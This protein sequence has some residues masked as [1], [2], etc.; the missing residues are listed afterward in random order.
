MAKTVVGLF[1][2]F[3]EAQSVVQDLVSNGFSRDHISVV[4]N[5]RSQTVDTSR[6]VGE[7]NTAAEGAGAGAV[8]G[9]VVGG[10]V[11][12]LVGLGVLAIPGIGPVLAAGP[13]VA[14][15]G[16]PAAVAGATALGAGLG[17]A[18]GGLVGGLIGAGVPED[19]A[20]YY[21]E[22]VRRGGTLVSVTTDD[23]SMADRAYN[24]MRQHNAVDIKDRGATYRESG[25]SRFDPDS[26][27]Y[28]PGN[29]VY[30]D[31]QNKWEESSKV[32]TAGGGLA[33]AATGAAIGAVGGPVGAV[34]GG[35]AG[36]V[37]GAG[38]GAAGDI[39]G[40]DAE[41]EVDTSGTA[42]AD[43]GHDKA[44]VRGSGEFSSRSNEMGS[45]SDAGNDWQESS[46][47]GT[48]TGTAAGAATGAAIGA[49]GGPVGAVIGGVA[50]AAAG[51]GVGA[52]GDIAGERAEDASAD[53]S[54]EYR[55]INQSTGSSTRMSGGS[56]ASLREQTMGNS[57]IAD[58]NTSSRMSTSGS[59][60][61]GSTMRS[62]M[63]DDESAVIPVVEEDLQV[64][65]R[66]VE[67]GT[68]RVRSHVEETPVEEQVRLREEQVRVE[69]RPVNRPVSDADMAAFKETS[70]EVREVDEEPVVAKQA[71]IVEEVVV[72][73]DVTE[74][75]ETIRDTVR[76]TQVDID[77]SGVER[78]VGGMMD[79][80][81]YE[82]DFRSHYQ[83]TYGQSGYSY[84]DYSPV[85]RYGYGL[86]T[87]Q[88]YSNRPWNEIEPEA[89]R[90]WEEYNPNTWEQ[91][92]DSIQYAW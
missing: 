48:A 20:N 38:V 47:A 10:A 31:D 67:R 65:K 40:K 9:T 61:S 72:K 11:G 50:G 60:M 77:Q 27:P 8:G 18:A 19:E 85:Y 86:A 26:G 88:R 1:D 91:F 59:S 42:K 45:S 66:E 6:E 89:R 82:N 58:T 90:R 68:T 63:S 62:S 15:I 83:T 33:G 7:S 17:A 69:R 25:W 43:Y 5:D 37:T 51:A 23:D 92:K 28:N 2:N 55:R 22:G 41:D 64:G 70:F 52:G 75:T 49:A 29:E 80:S 87:D 73:K 14:A 30:S 56:S 44:P 12:L 76:R 21:A 24:V 53:D 78:S 84:D 34:I 46:K 54:D 35:V 71:R 4:A 13:L 81:G 57:G 36:A 16:T 3:S 74:H 32:G 39:A 79:Y